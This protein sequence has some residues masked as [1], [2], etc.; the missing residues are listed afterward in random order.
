M[1]YV[2]R[3]RYVQPD[4]IGYLDRSGWCTRDQREAARFDTEAD[5]WDF[6]RASEGQV[7]TDVWAE[8]AT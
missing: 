5:A 2:V 8:E 3:C 6:A 1:S 4:G 7:I